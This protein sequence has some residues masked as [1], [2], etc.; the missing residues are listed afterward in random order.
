MRYGKCRFFMIFLAW[1]FVMGVY[2]SY[3]TPSV[4]EEAIEEALG[5]SPRLWSHLYTIYSAPNVILPV[6]G[7]MYCDKM[8]IRKGIITFSLIVT[9]G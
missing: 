2:F 3:D 4:I 6:L 1:M 8:G 7:G 5:I 9:F